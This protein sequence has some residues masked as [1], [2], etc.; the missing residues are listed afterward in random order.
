MGEIGMKNIIQFPAEKRSPD[1][2]ET[3]IREGLIKIGI[4][5]ALAAHHATAVRARIKHIKADYQY[6]IPPGD[7]THDQVRE[8]V[9][10][11]EAFMQRKSTEYLFVILMMQIELWGATG[12]DE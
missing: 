11:V 6:D 9:S 4:E 7:L 1:E 12:G 2:M 3:A 10:G 8:V 5:P